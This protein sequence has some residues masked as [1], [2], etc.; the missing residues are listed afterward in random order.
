MR[1]NFKRYDIFICCH[2][3]DPHVSLIGLDLFGVFFSFLGFRVC[4]LCKSERLYLRLPGCKDFLEEKKVGFG[5]GLTRVDLRLW[6]FCCPCDLWVS[7]D[8]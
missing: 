1:I 7:W 8:N 5:F 6:D 3:S 2:Y 4:V